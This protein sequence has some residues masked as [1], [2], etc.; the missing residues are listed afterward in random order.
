ML[1]QLFQ[2]TNVNGVQQYYNS[3]RGFVRI[4]RPEFLLPEA[5]ATNTTSDSRE[6]VECSVP[7]RIN[8]DSD[9][10]VLLQYHSNNHT[11]LG[12][13]RHTISRQLFDFGRCEREAGKGS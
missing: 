7:G 10:Y 6:Y 11:E 4:L 9:H 1:H 8:K 12:I 3:L 13:T 5:V 2:S